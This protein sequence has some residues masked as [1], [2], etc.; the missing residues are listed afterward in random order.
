MT[1]VPATLTVVDP[2]R[3]PT[4]AQELSNLSSD[5]YERNFGSPPICTA[6]VGGVFA[7]MVSGA[8]S[9]SVEWTR[10]RQKPRLANC[11]AI[12]KQNGC[13]DF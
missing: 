6:N 2:A 9:L 5:V 7:P 11:T 13:D 3:L 4:M 1:A 8:D 10:V 12:N